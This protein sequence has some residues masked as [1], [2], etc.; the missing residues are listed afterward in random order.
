MHA[1]AAITS[2]VI[3][4]LRARVGLVRML[5]GRRKDDTGL[6]LSRIVRRVPPIGELSTAA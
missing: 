3:R 4:R 2:V 1:R 6:Y 5:S